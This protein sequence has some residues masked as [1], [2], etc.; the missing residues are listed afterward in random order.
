MPRPFCLPVM[1]GLAP[2]VGSIAD[3]EHRAEQEASAGTGSGRE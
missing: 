3:D 2:V 1:A